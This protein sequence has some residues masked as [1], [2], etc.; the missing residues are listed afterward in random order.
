MEITHES[1]GGLGRFAAPRLNVF[2]D[3]TT[4]VGVADFDPIQGQFVFEILRI[5]SEMDVILQAQKDGVTEDQMSYR[6]AQRQWAADALASVT[7][8]ENLVAIKAYVSKIPPPEEPKVAAPKPVRSTPITPLAPA[9]V[10]LSIEQLFALVNR[11]DALETKLKAADDKLKAL[12]AAVKEFDFE[13]CRKQLNGFAT[14]ISNLET[15]QK[16]QATHLRIHLR[17][18]F[19]G[20]GGGF[21]ADR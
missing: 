11:V 7:S 12:E 17:H 9:P 15:E 19:C 13:S 5:P 3:K 14:R 10:D 2:V 8:P 4:R 1:T 18:C 20:S 6:C 16:T 21:A